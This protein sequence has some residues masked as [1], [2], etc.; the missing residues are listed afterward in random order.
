MTP[1]EDKKNTI[2]ASH[3]PYIDISCVRAG[4]PAYSVCHFPRLTGI[5]GPSGYSQAAAEP[6][7][8]LTGSIGEGLRDNSAH[9]LVRTYRSFEEVTLKTGRCEETSMFWGWAFSH[10]LLNQGTFHLQEVCEG[11]GGFLCWVSAFFRGGLVCAL[12][13]FQ[14]WQ[15]RKEGKKVLNTG[16][17]QAIVLVDTLLVGYLP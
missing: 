16:V 17:F 8:S 3:Q 6:S 15:G 14:W 12:F 4:F 2:S 9:L 13:I 11:V 7:E 10:L 5:V 1:V